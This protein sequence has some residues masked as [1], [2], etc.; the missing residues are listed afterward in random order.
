MQ[1]VEILTTTTVYETEQIWWVWLIFGCIIA[2]VWLISS[3]G[4]YF[5]SYESGLVSVLIGLE[6]SGLAILLLIIP[7]GAMATKNLDTVD[8]Y[9]HEVMIDETVNMTEFLDKYEIVDERGKI[10]TVIEDVN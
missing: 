8:Y 3:L 1:G 4:L 2:A 9:K 10:L 7:F 6:I 5:S